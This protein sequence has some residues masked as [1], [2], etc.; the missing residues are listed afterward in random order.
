MRI[1]N[2]SLRRRTWPARLLLGALFVMV[3]VSACGG[4]SQNTAQPTDAAVAEP[5]GGTTSAPAAAEGGAAA[6]PVADV[7]V[8]L[9]YLEQGITSFDHAYWTSQLL[10]SQGTIF[11]GLYGYDPQLNVVPKIAE[12]ATPYA[13]NTVWTI[14]LRQDKK[15]SNGDPVTAKDFYASWMRADGSRAQ[16]CA[17]V[18]RLRRAW[19]RRRTRIRRAPPRPR[20]S[21]SSCSTTIR[22][23]SR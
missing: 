9:P 20:R 12:S 10:V 8:T 2:P 17:D 21:V 18:G 15:W 6:L 16:R 13:D 3:F 4:T 11:E 7:T 22:S 14:K 1:A 19:S 5:A 23:R